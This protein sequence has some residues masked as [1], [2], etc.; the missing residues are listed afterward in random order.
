MYLTFE[1]A[2]NMIKPNGAKNANYSATRIRQLINLG[3]L[4]EAK[5]EIFVDDNSIFVSLGYIKTE[6]LVTEESVKRY[7]FE[8]KELKNKLGKIPKK[9]REVKAYF[10]DDSY[11]NFMSI[12]AACL[13]FGI[14]R[15]KIMRSIEKKKFIKVKNELIKF[16]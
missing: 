8:R 15:D 7:I 11:S 1:Q 14:S 12:D 10:E 5:P 16:V 9:N 6:G 3:H 4:I 2:F 13:F